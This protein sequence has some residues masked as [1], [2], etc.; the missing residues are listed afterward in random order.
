VAELTFWLFGA[1]A[2]IFSILCVTRRNPVYGA[3]FLLMTLGS[4]AVEFLL[5]HSP[6]IAA[7]QIILYAGAIV[8]LFVF[9]IMLL[10]LKPEEM[11]EEGPRSARVGSAVLA[12][13]VFVLLS[14]PAF[15]GRTFAGRTDENGGLKPLKNPVSL[16]TIVEEVASRRGLTPVQLTVGT[17]KEDSKQ[18]ESLNQRLVR[19]QQ[20]VIYLS[21]QLCREDKKDA[22]G[23]T[24]WRDG[25]RAELRRMFRLESEALDLAINAVESSF[26]R[27]KEGKPEASIGSLEGDAA[28]VLILG[29]MTRKI[30]IR[31]ARYG[32][33]EH[34]VDF[35]YS[36]Y[37]VAF[38]LVSILIFAAI[39]GVLVLARRRGFMGLETEDGEYRGGSF[40]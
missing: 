26:V 19:A 39:A 29:T 35:L 1:M 24:K 22:T 21:S 40:L 32:S 3:F 30:K 5:L 31:S 23:E 37:V 17:L 6:F 25:V 13:L 14:L 7:M 27:M 10:S 20:D 34:F 15:D 18:A 36:R 12:T 33:I 38:E 4:L 9:V 28:H 16:R 11:G 2:V 8:V